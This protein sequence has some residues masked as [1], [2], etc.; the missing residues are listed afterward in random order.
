MKWLFVIPLITGWADYME[1]IFLAIS[2]TG[3]PS[4]NHVAVVL[5]SGATQLKM[6]FN[7]LLILSLLFTIGI[8][9]AS[10]FQKHTQ[11]QVNISGK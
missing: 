5:A 1:N 4:P 10:L 6:L 8:W 9:V 7:I 2:F 3:Y 11:G